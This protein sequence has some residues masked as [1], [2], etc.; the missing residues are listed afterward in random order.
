MSL[1]HSGLEMDS[2]T[3]G[4]ARHTWPLSPM[5]GSL[6]LR[7]AVGPLEGSRAKVTNGKREERERRRRKEGKHVGGCGGLSHIA[8]LRILSII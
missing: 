6:A 8:S 4:W 5:D 7:T 3:R 2:R 1:K